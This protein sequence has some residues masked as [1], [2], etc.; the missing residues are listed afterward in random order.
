MFVASKM[1]DENVTA[2]LYAYLDKRVLM[3]DDNT[4]RFYWRVEWEHNYS[5]A[6]SNEYID[7]VI[8]SLPAKYV[9]DEFQKF[10][11]SNL[12]FGDMVITGPSH[13]EMQIPGLQAQVKHPCTGN[14]DTLSSVIINLN[15]TQKWS[16]EQIADWLETLD[17]NPILN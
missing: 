2:Y 7:S 9:N 12:T 5:K 15:D 13:Y 1:V 17:E 10:W 16:R 11:K 6:K 14:L 8:A 3:L 4:A